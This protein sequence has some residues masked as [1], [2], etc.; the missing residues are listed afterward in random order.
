MAFIEWEEKHNIAVK[1]FNDDHKKLFGYINEL[2]SG[3]KSGLGIQDMGYIL[4]NLVNYTVVH[5][6]RE[7]KFMIKHNY[8]D[9]DDHKI[10]HEF[11][12]KKVSDFQSEFEQG[13][14]A[15][16]IELL[17]FLNDWITNHILITDMKYK[18]FFIEVAKN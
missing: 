16:S 6:H 14:K 11:L 15:F 17:S 10:E 13:K 12:I 8:P 1:Q 2:H 18:Q 9:H 5:F 7:E 3:L 4:K